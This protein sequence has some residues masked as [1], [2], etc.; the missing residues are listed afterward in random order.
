MVS[1]CQ[2]RPDFY[3]IRQDLLIILSNNQYSIFYNEI[4]LFGFLWFQKAVHLLEERNQNNY[5]IFLQ[6]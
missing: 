1:M 5:S 2:R 6:H 3:G 4:N